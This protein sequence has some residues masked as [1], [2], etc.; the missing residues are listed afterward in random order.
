M[1]KVTL[2]NLCK[3]F[4]QIKAVD[5]LNLEIAAG[6]FLALLGPSG[7]GKTT[8]LLTIAGFY[9]PDQ[10][11]IYFDEQLVNDLPPRLRNIG[12]VFQ[13][14]AL[15]PHMNVLDNIAFPLKLQKVPKS[16]WKARAIEIAKLLEIADLLDR[17]PGQLSG[18]QQ[19]RVALARALVRNPKLLLLDEPLSNLD[20]KLRIFMRAELKRL[21]K[22][23]GITTIFVTHDQIEAMTMADRIVVLREGRL[24]QVGTPDEL[25]DSPANVFVASFIGTPPMNLL[26]AE[27]E[28]GKGDYRVKTSH[29][30]FSLPKEIVAKIKYIPSHGVVLGIR[31][32]DLIIGE[33]NIRG[34][35]YVVE[36]LGRDEL[37]TLEA[38]D[39]RL[40][41]L[42]PSRLRIGL[43]DKIE[44]SFSVER[45]HLFDKETG[46]S[47]YEEA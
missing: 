33:G 14:Y 24:Q 39:M 5:G 9:K 32:E 44:F 28:V 19:Q 27:I 41:A 30:S 31:P 26:D 37:V 35:V 36:P 2:R 43:N 12:M 1:M 23:L 38:G 3:Y 8:T 16:E 7:C 46:K 20:A 47:L 29:F 25:Y 6:E 11:E 4:Q 22:E 34:L 40:K 21:Q 13:S 18:G 15:Y 10:G 17:K 45:V 42:V